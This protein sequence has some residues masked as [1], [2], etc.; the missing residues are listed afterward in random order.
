MNLKFDR[1]VLN[2]DDLI[3]ILPC[4][5]VGKPLKAVPSVDAEI[6]TRGV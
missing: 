3:R 1:M 4:G 6:V 2:F 5:I